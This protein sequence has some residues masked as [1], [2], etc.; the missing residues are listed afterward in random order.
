MERGI[1]DKVRAKI[2]Q[3][4]KEQEQI[5]LAR[6]AKQAEMNA[7]AEAEIIAKNHLLQ[8]KMKEQEAIS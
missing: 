1:V 4:E 8:S 5:R 6:A 2:E 7:M 3:E